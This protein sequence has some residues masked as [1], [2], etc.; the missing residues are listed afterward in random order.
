MLIIIEEKVIIGKEEK[1][2]QEEKF[3]IVPMMKI[4]SIYEY[5][6]ITLK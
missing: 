5:Q 4:E 2:L 1:K 3:T 6:H